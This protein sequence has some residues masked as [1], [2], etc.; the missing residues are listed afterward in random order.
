MKCII[1]DI[2]PESFIS[3][4]NNSVKTIPPFLDTEMKIRVE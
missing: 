4:S 2:Y 1:K 3:T